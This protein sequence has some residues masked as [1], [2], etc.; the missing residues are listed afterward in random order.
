MQLVPVQ[1][2]DDAEEA[3]DLVREYV[4]R[5]GLGAHNEGLEAELAAFLDHY[6][7]PGGCF[8]LARAGMD[9]LG[10]GGF[11]RRSPDVCEMRRLYVRPAARGRHLGRGLVAALVGTARRLGYRTMVLDT[12]PWMTEA[13]GL[14]RAFGFRE[15]PAYYPSPLPDALYFGLDLVPLPASDAPPAA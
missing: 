4:A 15:I 8:L 13:Q 6:G 2:D 3:A 14:Y 10:G 7:P 5:L 9:V 1:T 11:R 12:L